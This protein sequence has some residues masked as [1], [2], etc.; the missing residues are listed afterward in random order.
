MMEHHFSKDQKIIGFLFLFAILFVSF[1]SLFS[2]QRI[3]NEQAISSTS[4]AAGLTSYPK[5]APSI[6]N[7]DKKPNC[8]DNCE[9]L[10]WSGFNIAMNGSNELAIAIKNKYL[11]D[12]FADP[13][14]KNAICDYLLT[15]NWDADDVY[16]AYE[17]LFCTKLHETACGN[18]EMKRKL[19]LS[20]KSYS[21]WESSILLQLAALKEELTKQY[22]LDCDLLQN[23]DNPVCLEL[24]KIYSK[25]Q[26]WKAQHK[27]FCD[28]LSS[29]YND[30]A[31][32]MPKPTYT[33]I[34]LTPL[35][36]Q[37]I[38]EGIR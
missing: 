26:M 38:G 23:K 37:K 14:P 31:C 19:E 25:I 11:L 2:I 35:P 28:N 18:D 27:A 6:I 33:R 7:Q 20:C 16:N 15:I 1:I 13:M 22:S 3:Y 10:K 29:C 8:Q 30:F 36:S 24:S 21:P 5:D 17:Y 32:V 34:L 12:C 9:D 4:Q